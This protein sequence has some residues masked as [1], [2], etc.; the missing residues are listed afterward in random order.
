MDD[1][2]TPLDFLE[3]VYTNEDLE[4]KVRMKAVEIAIP[5]VH[6]KLSQ[7]AVAISQVDYGSV[8]RERIAR[9]VEIAKTPEEKAQASQR[10]LEWDSREPR[11]L[12]GETPGQ[13]LERRAMER[14]SPA[15]FEAVPA[16]MI[17]GREGPK[18][19]A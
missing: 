7:S 5:F 12:P 8:L 10:L 3:E 17:R 1:R 4:L 15:T 13:F 14:T 16:P 9:R 6:P 11:V 19:R 18:R 2:V